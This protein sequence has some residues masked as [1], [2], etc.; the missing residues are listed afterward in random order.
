MHSYSFTVTEYRSDRPWLVVGQERRTVEL[1]DQ[2]N[3]FEW[4][5]RAWPEPRFSVQLDPVPG[6]AGRLGLVRRRG[7]ARAVRGDV[8]RRVPT[9]G[10]S[11]CVLM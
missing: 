1:D 3:F 9:A 7:K 2:A 10:L 8:A 5:H 11:G 6:A 4:A